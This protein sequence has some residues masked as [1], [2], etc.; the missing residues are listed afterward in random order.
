MPPKNQ[1]ADPAV[2][3][4]GSE[5]GR[6]PAAKKRAAASARAQRDRVAAAAGGEDGEDSFNE[7]TF[8]L[9]IAVKGHIEREL[10]KATRVV[11]KP[12]V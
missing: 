7:T 8:N 6:P 2:E 9:A 11:A 5:E 3:E 1:S 12:Y 4:T 10:N